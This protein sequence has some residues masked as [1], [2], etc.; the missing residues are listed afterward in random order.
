MW[1]FV[2]YR[3]ILIDFRLLGDALALLVLL[4]DVGDGK[5]FEDVLADCC[6]SRSPSFGGGGFCAHTWGKRLLQLLGLVLVLEDE[7]VEVAVAADLELDLLGRGLLDA[8][9]CLLRN[10]KSVVWFLLLSQSRG[11]GGENYA[12]EASLRRQ[13]SMNCLMS[14]TWEGMLAV[15]FE[16]CV[17]ALLAAR[18]LVGGSCCA[19][20]C[21]TG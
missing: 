19:G 14:R 21:G 18:G 2:I 20:F 13:I 17:I 9:S 6:F 15:W 10:S 11:F 7:G 4:G 12:Q 16:A 1:S 5:A 8:G 3:H